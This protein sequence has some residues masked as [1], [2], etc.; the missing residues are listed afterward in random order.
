MT[1]NENRSEHPTSKRREDSFWYMNRMELEKLTG[2]HTE[3]GPEL[4]KPAQQQLTMANMRTLIRELTA[5][6]IITDRYEIPEDVP[7]A[8]RLVNRS[9]RKEATD[10]GF[11]LSVFTPPVY[12]MV[13]SIYQN[14]IASLSRT[15]ATPEDLQNLKVYVWIDNLQCHRVKSVY[16]HDNEL[17]EALDLAFN[18]AHDQEHMMTMTCAI[19]TDNMYQFSPTKQ[20]ARNE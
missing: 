19:W 18:Q 8:T 9:V 12:Q 15:V 10:S 14:S 4:L 16:R 6:Q 1:T 11:I 20:V 13:R 3:F 5:A 7:H 17:G 2:R